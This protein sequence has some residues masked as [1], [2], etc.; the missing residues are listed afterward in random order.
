MGGA[1]AAGGPL[2]SDHYVVNPPK[3]TPLTNFSVGD[4]IVGK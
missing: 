2:S 3:V 1:S 4:G